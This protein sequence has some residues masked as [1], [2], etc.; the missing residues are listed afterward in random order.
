MT[1]QLARVAVL[2]AV[3]LLVLPASGQTRL[4][5]ED[6]GSTYSWPGA[7]VVTVDVQ[8]WAAA[9]SAARPT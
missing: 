1:R 9:M 5:P 8:P 6:D 7:T 3:I 2:V 4:P